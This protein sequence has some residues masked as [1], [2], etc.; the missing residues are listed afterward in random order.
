MS[1]V[2][3]K[4]EDYY[5]QLSD[6]ALLQE[7]D[8]GQ[9]RHR[10]EAWHI[11]HREATSRGL[12]DRTRL[13]TS[14]DGNS[15]DQVAPPVTRASLQFEHASEESVLLPAPDGPSEAEQ[16]A[17]A[18]KQVRSAA[19]TALALAALQ[20]VLGVSIGIAVRDWSVA[21]SL[22]LTA[23][24]YMGL[25]FWLSLR[26]SPV[27]S[28][29]LVTV[30]VGSALLQF[31]QGTLPR[32][33]MLLIGILVWYGFLWSRFVRGHRGAMRLRALAKTP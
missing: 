8:G 1:D 19:I 5:R 20:I 31:T 6:A 26:R 27:A 18:A 14:I 12:L 23:V 7:Y 24:V 4:L 32:V 15:A 10:A 11:I 30:L 28:A 16:R 29:L 3:Q 2:T 21:A 33:P 17:D 13:D 25:G 22:L 9:E